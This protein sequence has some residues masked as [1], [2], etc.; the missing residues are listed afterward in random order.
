VHA[1]GE[2]CAY[3]TIGGEIVRKTA[4]G[5]YRVCRDPGKRSS[6]FRPVDARPGTP[7]PPERGAVHHNTSR[8]TKGD[9]MDRM[10]LD[11]ET[12]NVETFEPSPALEAA[13]FCTSD[14]EESCR[15]NCT[16]DC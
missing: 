4:R 1:H 16:R 10:I 8:R 5:F 6:A 7:H 3:H 14:P 9:K 13:E 15:V 2:N 12:L 11:L